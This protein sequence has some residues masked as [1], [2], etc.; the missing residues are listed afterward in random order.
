MHHLPGAFSLMDELQVSTD[1]EKKKSGSFHVLRDTLWA[2]KHTDLRDL[3]ARH[4]ARP[5]DSRGEFPVMWS[6]L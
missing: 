6:D 2:M 5:F 1:R 3:A 4:A